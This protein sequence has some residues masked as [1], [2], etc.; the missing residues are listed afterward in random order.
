M[1]LISLMQISFIYFG[2]ELFRA[3]PL[4]LQDLFTVILISFTVVIFDFISK[5]ILKYLK[6]KNKIKKRSGGIE[7]VE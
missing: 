3:V 1:I 2:G 7:N 4:K 6:H 5:V